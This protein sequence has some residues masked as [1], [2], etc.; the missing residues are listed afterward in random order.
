[1]Q[2]RCWG[3]SRQWTS[4]VRRATSCSPIRHGSKI[5]ISGMTARFR[6][7]RPRTP[8]IKMNQQ[9]RQHRHGNAQTGKDI[10]RRRQQARTMAAR[11]IFHPATP[12]A[13][14]SEGA[15]SSQPSCKTGIITAI[16]ITAEKESWKPA[17]RIRCGLGTSR[18]N[19][20]TARRLADRACALAVPPPKTVK[21]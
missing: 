1:M 14:R 8:F 15:A 5:S 3:S 17:S 11:A 18:S 9:K 19:A 16:P 7:Y 21:T 4:A 13:T 2:R 20:A 6:Q 12:S 10:L